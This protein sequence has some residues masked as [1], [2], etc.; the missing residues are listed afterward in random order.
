MELSL[1]R[2]DADFHAGHAARQPAPQVFGN[3]HIGPRTLGG[4]H[5]G[6]ARFPPSDPA[7]VRQP[8]APTRM[9]QA[10]DSGTAGRTICS[11]WRA[12][13][14]TRSRRVPTSI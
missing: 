4:R 11:I 7:F 10:E 1:G 6:Q 12:C 8:V 5:Q 14:S 2:P 9:T 13:R 3:G